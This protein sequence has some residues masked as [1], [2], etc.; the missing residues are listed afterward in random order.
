MS[1]PLTCGTSSSLGYVY[2]R[3]SATPA[4]ALGSSVKL[5]RDGRCT[6]TSLP[7]EEGLQSAPCAQLG[8]STFFEHVADEEPGVASRET[9]TASDE[10]VEEKPQLSLTMTLVLV[11]LV[12]VVRPLL[13]LFIQVVDPLF[14]SSL[15]SMQSRLSNPWI[16][17]PELS[18]RSGSRSSYFPW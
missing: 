13:P 7:S 17:C 3:G 10:P 15:P 4:P 1:L 14:F 16:N 11:T 8:E 18:A 12:T 9:A 6:G 2:S 5:V